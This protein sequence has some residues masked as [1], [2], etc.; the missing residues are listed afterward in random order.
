[1]LDSLSVGPNTYWVEAVG[2]LLY[3]GNRDGVR[4][5]DAADVHN[6]RVRGFVP[7]PYSVKRLTYASPHVYAACWDAGVAIIESTQVAIDEPTSSATS[8]WGNPHIA[9]NPARER[10][11]LRWS[12]T[13]GTGVAV[14]VRDVTGRVII[15]ID[16]EVRPGG[17]LELNLRH[18]VPGLYFAELAAAGRKESV[19]FVKR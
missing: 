15:R 8:Q 18:L 1:M 2:E 12:A 19:K 5:V 17:Q 10:A 11:T 14:T 6:M 4:V 7:T 13:A 16:L 3:V 9:P